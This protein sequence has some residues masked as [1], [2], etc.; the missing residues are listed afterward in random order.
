MIITPRFDPPTSTVARCEPA[1]PGPGSPRMSARLVR[2]QSW[3]SKKPPRSSHRGGSCHSKQSTML[4]AFFLV[5]ASLGAT[6]VRVADRR[7]SSPAVQNP[8]GCFHPERAGRFKVMGLGVRLIPI[9]YVHATRRRRSSA[10]P[11]MPTRPSVAGSGT[12]APTRMLSH[13]VPAVAWRL[14]ILVARCGHPNLRA[15]DRAP[16]DQPDRTQLS[17]R[18]WVGPG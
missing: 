8:P 10:R 4:I 7:N 6:A 18:R 17:G 16:V 12:S 13:A 15:A 3:T 5:I 11:A 9:A 14:G 2:S 1:R